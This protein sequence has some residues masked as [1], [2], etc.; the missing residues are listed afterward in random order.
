[1][2]FVLAKAYPIYDVQQLLRPVLLVLEPV[3]D[4]LTGGKGI[5]VPL[6]TEEEV[7]I[8]LDEGGKAGMIETEEVKMIKNV[9][10]LNDITAEDAMRSRSQM[11]V[12][13]GNLRLREARE[14]LFR[15][16]YSR[17][18]VYEGTIDNITGILYKT[19]ALTDL[20]Q[21]FGD[22]RLKDIA[23]PALFVTST[24][25]ADDLMKQFQL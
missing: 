16:K 20:A 18:P 6:V 10:Q 14:Q 8:M 9:F 2:P 17:I 15:S 7:K 11:F 22:T 19:R 4:K 24:K 3:I 5:T 13:D 23:S 21:G 25:P 1:M 12:L